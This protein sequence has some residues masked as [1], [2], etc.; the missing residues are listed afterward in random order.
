VFRQVA[1][2]V[3][4][5]KDQPLEKVRDSILAAASKAIDESHLAG[6]SMIV[7]TETLSDGITFNNESRMWEKGA[8]TFEFRVTA[9]SESRESSQKSIDELLSSFEVR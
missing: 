9:L 1:A 4:I 2:E 6:G 7:E 5:Y 8:A 3:R